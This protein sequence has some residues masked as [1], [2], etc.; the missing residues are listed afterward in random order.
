[1]ISEAAAA[2][3]FAS[4]PI[5]YS[6]M[7]DG[8]EKPGYPRGETGVTLAVTG[9]TTASE[10]TSPNVVA[11]LR[12]SD[13]ALAG[14]HV[15]VSAHLDHVGVG[16]AVEG[17]TIYNGFYDNALG[18]AIV[19]ESAR[20]LAALPERPRRSI[21]FLLVTGEEKGLLGSEYFAAYPTVPAASLVANV[22]IDM[23]LVRRPTA[24][25]VALGF[26]HSSLS[27]VAEAA[28]GAHGFTLSPDPHPEEVY[29]IRS[30][31]YSFVRRGVPA[32]NFNLGARSPDG[33]AEQAEAME[34]FLRRCYHRPC[35]EVELGADWET[36]GRYAAVNADAILRIADEPARPSWNAGDFFGTTFGG[37]R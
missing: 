8:A 10:R 26:E 18:S 2:R 22:N 6:A 27:A 16:A 25:L 15:V 9:R 31:Q 28:A 21:L 12:G 13:P 36:M 37:A 23:P 14:E 19:L 20:A 1:L 33:G 11:I 17:D 5:P 29:F 34:E 32:L 7:L 30:D 24:D 35:D 3:I 4:G